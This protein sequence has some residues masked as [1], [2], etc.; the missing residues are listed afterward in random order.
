M[1]FDIRFENER[2]AEGCTFLDVRFSAPSYQAATG[3]VINGQAQLITC[4]G[5]DSAFIYGSDLLGWCVVLGKRITPDQLDGFE[6]PGVSIDTRDDGGVS[7]HDFATLEAAQRFVVHVYEAFYEAFYLGFDTYAL[8]DAPAPQAARPAPVSSR[9]VP[10]PLARDVAPS[11]LP[12]PAPGA[13]ERAVLFDASAYPHPHR[14]PRN[15][16]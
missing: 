14:H 6:I 9:S 8:A 1:S 16:P 15:T 3:I 11:S 12:R 7:A 13:T 4:S 2:T 10:A 5:D